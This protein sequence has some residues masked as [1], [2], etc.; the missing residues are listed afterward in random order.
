MY[1]QSLG[2]LLSGNVEVFRANRTSYLV[3]MLR[4]DV[5][6]YHHFIGL[7]IADCSINP[8]IPSLS[9]VSFVP[10]WPCICS[11]PNSS[12]FCYYWRSGHAGGRGL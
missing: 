12:G 8:V 3:S 6:F 2:L 11:V 9:Q 4:H 10:Y 5:T 1:D 7:H